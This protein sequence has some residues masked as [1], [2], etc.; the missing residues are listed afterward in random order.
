MVFGHIRHHC[1]VG[2][3]DV[4]GIVAAQ[5]AHFHHSHIHSFVCEPHEGCGRDQ[6]KPRKPLAAFGFPVL[7]GETQNLQQVKQVRVRNRVGV[8]AESFVDAGDMRAGVGARFE[9]VLGQQLGEEISGG[10][11]AIGAG[12][13]DGGIVTLRVAQQSGEVAHAIQ[14]KAGDFACGGFQI[15]VAV[16][17]HHE[18]LRA[19]Q[20]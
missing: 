20:P 16:E 4:G 15:D 19:L 7:F 18:I 13:V 1:Y 14:R 17:P 9:T 5:L 11:F 6:L 10:A 3:Q 2:I 12:D 8:D